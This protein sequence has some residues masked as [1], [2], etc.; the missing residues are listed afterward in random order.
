[1]SNALATLSAGGW[2]RGEREREREGKGLEEAEYGRGR[3][4][5]RRPHDS[6]SILSGLEY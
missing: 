6:Q 2:R 1:M 5:V 4:G 3:G